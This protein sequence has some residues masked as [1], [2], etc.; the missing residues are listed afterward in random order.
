[1]RKY[2]WLMGVLLGV[3][4]AGAEVPPGGQ[5]LLP[6]GELKAYVGRA[7]AQGASAETVPVAGRAFAM[8]Q[9]VILPKH[10]ANPWDAGAR[11]QLVGGLREGEVGLVTFEARALPL[12][13]QAPEEAEAGG[14]VYL[15]E[16]L[17][18]RY[19]KAAE[20]SFKCGPQWQTFYLAFQ[21]SR[22]LPEGKGALVFHLGQ[23]AQAFELGPVRVINYGNQIALKDLPRTRMTYRGREADA[24]WRK[25]AQERI[26]RN[27]MAPLT[28]KVTGPGGQPVAGATV[29][30]NQRR[31]AF[32]FGSAVTA[33]WLT[34]PGTDGETYRKIVESSF[35]RVV[36][37]NDLKM[38]LWETSLKNGEGN[39]FRWDHTQQACDWLKER[40]IGIRG[41][42]LSWA[43]WEPWSEKLKNEPDKI[44]QRILDHIPRMA[45][46]TGDRVMEWD[47]INHLAG[48]DRNIDESTGL[49]FYTE[50]MKACRAATKLPLWVN[51]DQV[52]RP[53]RQQEDYYTRIQKLIADGQK[54]DGIGNQA[55]LDDSFLPG[56]VEVLA[57]SDRFAALVPALQ[58]TEFD[59][60]THGDEQ[61]EADYLR[62][63]LTVCYSHP[64]YTG[65]LIWGFWEGAHWK[66]QTA[67]WRQDWSEKP[68]A[69]VWKDLVNHRWATREEGR[70][71]V[72]GSWQTRAHLGMYEITVTAAGRPATTVQAVLTRDGAPVMVPLP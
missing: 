3:P 63:M 58:I 39:A 69:K 6:S 24:P 22:S 40:R 1:M 37:E 41:H 31:S 48:W 29:Q 21:A 65:F 4:G 8:A 68:S 12:T 71:G 9:R 57:N 28:V 16:P 54:P 30:V 43:P 10:P 46:E 56:P 72:D 55:H 44:R 64:A 5:D 19:P 70:T 18:P 17:P 62:D 33:D 15:E 42:Y 25:E 14:A 52:F 66:P 36:F 32:G 27:R 26:T 50:I 2:L 7:S 60:F 53:G 20:L 23:R 49:D 61:L 45:A 67:L 59:V 34:R 35:S 47:A 11:S 38:G 51:E 13:G